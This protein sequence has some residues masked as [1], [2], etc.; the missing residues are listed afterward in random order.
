MPKT[1]ESGTLL[2]TADTHDGK[3]KLPEQAKKSFDQIIDLC[4][5]VEPVALLHSGDWFEARGR[6]PMLSYN[7]VIKTLQ[8]FFTG[9]NDCPICTVVGNHDL[10]LAEGGLEESA[11]YGLSELFPSLAVGG[12]EPV[13]TRIRGREGKTAAQVHL[14][15]YSQSTE[16]L[17]QRIYDYINNTPF[18]SS[19]IQ[20][21]ML[22]Q[23]TLASE[24]PSSFILD[25]GLDVERISS[26]FDFV[27]IGDNHKPQLL[28]DNVLI[29]GCPYASDFADGEESRG[30]W[31]LE[32][33]GKE[34]TYLELVPL[35]GPKFI[36][37]NVDEPSDLPP[38]FYPDNFYRLYIPDTQ[39][40]KVRGILGN[41]YPNVKPIPVVSTKE[42]R[43]KAVEG[44]KDVI[45]QYI[46]YANPDGLDR[47]KLEKL[48]RE[49][50]GGAG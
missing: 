22:H 7:R 27:I 34:L 36:T 23:V 46:Q 48:G 47:K 33:V 6:V 35:D 5:E 21:A 13:S 18:D 40:G 28:L 19:V 24:T 9:V 49:L 44:S 1:K 29:P 45:K 37:M 10:A 14:F 38:K 30:V 31:Q 32:F 25:K 39:I 3:P 26:S 17:Y 11:L 41:R 43:I 12:L 20:I 8:R 42:S 2:I 50:L 16:K 15:G 4:K